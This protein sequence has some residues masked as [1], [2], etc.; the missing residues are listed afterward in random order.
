MKH[1]QNFLYYGRPIGL[2]GYYILL[3]WFLS[4]A[5][6]SSFFF[7]APVISGADCMSTILPHMIM[8]FIEFMTEMCCMRLDENTGLENSLKFA[9][10]T[11][12]ENL[13]GLYIRK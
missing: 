8:V 4:S 11:P 7:S 13:V 2:A 5:Y 10:S 6:F 3:L 9:I 1:N 12:S